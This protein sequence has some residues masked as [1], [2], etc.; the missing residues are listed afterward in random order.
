MLQVSLCQECSELDVGNN[1]EPESGEQSCYAECH[2]F[3]SAVAI[4][5][6]S[7]RL[8]NLDMRCLII[9]FNTIIVSSPGPL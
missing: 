7:H 1:G 8:A 5:D 9:S 4:N 3:I 6:N 2:K